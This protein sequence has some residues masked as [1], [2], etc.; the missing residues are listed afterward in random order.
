MKKVII[1]S[2]FIISAAFGAGL[3]LSIPKETHTANV[4]AFEPASVSSDLEHVYIAD[5]PDITYA[6]QV[7]A[8]TPLN[9]VVAVNAKTIDDV[10]EQEII[11]KTLTDACAAHSSQM[12]VIES[13]RFLEEYKNSYKN[14]DS[15][16][17]QTPNGLIGCVY[18]GSAA[19]L[20]L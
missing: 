13:T 15:K 10:T 12:Y 5:V 18:F 16:I 11:S 9:E 14:K 4:H 17:I 3:G 7:A 2:V 19:D 20:D 6:P 1:T 8:Q